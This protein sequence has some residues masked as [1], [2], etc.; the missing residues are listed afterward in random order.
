MAAREQELLPVGYV[1]I[2]FTMPAPLARLA[3]ANKRVVYEPVVSRRGGDTPPGRDHQHR[4]VRQ[5]V[6]G[7]DEPSDFFDVQ[8]LREPTW[9]FGYGVSSS[10]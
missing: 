4:A 6:G 7:F 2:V 10:K 5:A 9:A 1:H 8:D 3:L